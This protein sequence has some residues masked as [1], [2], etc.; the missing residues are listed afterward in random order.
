MSTACCPFD[1]YGSDGP[2]VLLLHGLGAN[3]TQPLTLLGDALGERGQILAPDLRGH[4]RCRLDESAPM[5]HHA[6]LA[7][8]VEQVLTSVWQDGP[9]LLAGISMGAAVVAELMAR[10]RIHIA[11]AVLIR[12][13]WR[14]QPSPPNLAGFPV[15]AAL[16]R[17][18]S[19]E[20][21]KR[22]LAGTPE[23][24]AIADVSGAAA[25]ALLAQF[26]DVGAAHRADRLIAIP[27]SAPQRPHINAGDFPLL[28]L[29]ADLDP[30]H[31]LS[32]AAG[33]AADLGARFEGVPPRY[34]APARHQRA[35]SRLVASLIDEL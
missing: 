18:C 21:G 19:P 29:G 25:A 20:D 22:R 16:L 12:P 9:V 7:E 6:Q 2:R 23:Y 17:A 35:A 33:V 30:V 13:A 24:R 1:L 31:P 3:R 32:L 4:G 8:D 28:V 26:D 10:Q 11:G 34:E 15:I 14:W 27:A 5:L